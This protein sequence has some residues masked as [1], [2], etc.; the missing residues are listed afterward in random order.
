MKVFQSKIRAIV[1]ALT[2]ILLISLVVPILLIVTQNP[3]SSVEA[4]YLVLAERN[5]SDVGKRQLSTLICYEAE[6]EGSYF[7]IIAYECTVATPCNRQ[8]RSFL[9]F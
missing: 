4:F 5:F 6:R 2:A 9:F 3:K 7:G 8:V 1:L